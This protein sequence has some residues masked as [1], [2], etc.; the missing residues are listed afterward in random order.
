MN[1]GQFKDHVSHTRAGSLKPFY[2]SDK[3]LY[4]LN[5]AIFRE[6]SNA[7]S[8]NVCRWMDGKVLLLYVV[9]FSHILNVYFNNY[10]TQPELFKV[11]KLVKSLK[12]VYINFYMFNFFIIFVTNI[13]CTTVI[14]RHVIL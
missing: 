10:L 7:L 13:N 3:Y 1:W 2:N 5:P 9:S 4:S 12:S 11:Y 14:P 6:N 8:Y